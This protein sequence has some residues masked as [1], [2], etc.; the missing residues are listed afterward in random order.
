MFEKPENGRIR[1]I[2]DMSVHARYSDGKVN[3][4]YYLCP[5]CANAFS[6]WI[7]YTPKKD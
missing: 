3:N 6:K 2:I 7:T 5:R 1:K 4:S